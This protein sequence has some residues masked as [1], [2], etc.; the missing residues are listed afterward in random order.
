MQIDAVLPSIVPPGTG[1]VTVTQ[2]GATSAPFPVTVVA[3]SPGTFSLN[4]SGSGPGT[5]FNVASDGSLTPNHLFNSATPGQTVT[6]YA[7]GLGPASDPAQEDDQPPVQAD[8][9]KI[10]FQVD[11]WVGTQQATVQYAGRS[12][13][14]AEDQVNFVVPTGVS[15]CYNEVAVSAGPPGGQTVSN[16]TS[17]AVA[18]NGG[19]CSDADGIDMANL[20]GVIS[21]KGSANVGVIGMLS[22]FLDLNVVALGATF[23][24]D[25]DTVNGEIVTLTEQQLNA[26]L[27]FVQFPSVNSCAVS[28]YLQYPFPT[29]PVLTGILGPVGWLDAGASLSIEGPNGTEPVP[30]NAS[31]EGYDGLVGG[32]TIEEL[33]LGGG[34]PPFFLNSSYAI[35]PGTFTVT[36]PGGANVGAF[37]AAATV[38]SA[39]S[40]FTWTNQSAI[41]A[42]TIPRDTPLA[43]TWSGGDPEGFV[44]I[45]ATASTLQSGVTPTATTPGIQVDCVAPASVGSF[46]IP[47]YV[48]QSLPSTIGSTALLPPGSLQVGPASGAV[49]IT[50]PSGLD[51]AYLYYHYVQGANVVWQ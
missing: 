19:T 2:N 26:S 32:A 45:V 9:R 1:V 39:A 20:R 6:L 14:T 41:T 44:E 38:S 31:G 11:V 49:Q 34:L 8:I 46:T 40:S 51:A 16:F 29:D 50:T 21:S 35:L 28:Q 17:L 33:L 25:N 4:G 36:A 42:G 15:G 48:L 18:R 13:Y 7:T 3:S 12:S 24:W 37:S 22:K 27:G 23:E 5:L 10:N 43:I 47:T 30:K